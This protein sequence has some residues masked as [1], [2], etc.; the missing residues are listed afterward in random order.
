MTANS[1]YGLACKQALETYKGVTGDTAMNDW[2]NTFATNSFVT[3][4]KAP[5]DCAC[6]LRSQDPIYTTIINEAQKLG[7]D[8]EA[9]IVGNIGCWWSPCQDVGNVLIPS[10]ITTANCP[11]VCAIVNNIINSTNINANDIKQKIKCSQSSIVTFFEEHKT[12]IF[13]GLSLLLVCLLA[14]LLIYLA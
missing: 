5:Y 6:V 12:I 8:I 11:N 2:C 10:S 3:V 9:G 7:G 4:T 14:V 13:I 1:I